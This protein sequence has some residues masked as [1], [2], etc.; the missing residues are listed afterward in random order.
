MSLCTGLCVCC[1]PCNTYMLYLIDIFILGFRLSGRDLLKVIT[2][3]NNICN[4][5]KRAH[6]TI[7]EI[8]LELVS[9]PK[10]HKDLVEEGMSLSNTL[11]LAI[12]LDANGK[13]LDHMPV[14]TKEKRWWDYQLGSWMG[15]VMLI[16]RNTSTKF[17]SLR[18]LLDSMNFSF[19]DDLKNI[20]EESTEKN[21]HSLGLEK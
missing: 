19:I 8:N 5:L 12:S 4:K 14:E 1:L 7:C 18:N 2:M 13:S 17:D 6:L 9:V 16:A 11:M 15:S 3:P 21:C 20:C 10:I